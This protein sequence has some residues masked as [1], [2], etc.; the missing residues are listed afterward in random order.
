MAGYKGV[1]VNATEH[2]K[3]WNEKVDLA[4][5]HLTQASDRM[6][7][8]ADRHRRE[9]EFN[10]GDKVLVRMDQDRFKVPKGLSTSLVRRFDGPFKVVQKISPVTYQLNLPFHLPT[11]PVFHVS[12]LRSH[13]PDKE[14]LTRN[15]LHRG[16]A[17][18]NGPALGK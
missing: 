9:L 3:S 10:V 18:C 2:L 7:K 6:K 13:H 16:S 14:D 8:F 5:Y 4:R 15:I 1:N 17:K 12:Q 11:H